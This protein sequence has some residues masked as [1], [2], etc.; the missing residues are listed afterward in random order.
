MCIFSGP[1][2]DVSKTK[3]FGRV[4]E[5]RQIIV[6]SMETEFDNPVA[7]IL[8]IPT[9]SRNENAVDFINMKEQPNF[10]KELDKPFE[11]RSR[12]MSKGLSMNPLQVHE[13]GNFIASFVPHRISFNRLD[14]AF[15]LSENVWDKLPQYND[16][17]FVVFQLKESGSYHP[18]AFSFPTKHKDKLYFPTVHVHEGTVEETGDFD[19]ALYFQGE[20]RQGPSRQQSYDRAKAYITSEVVDPEGFIYKT[21]LYGVLPNRDTYV[22]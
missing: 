19:H 14:E 3:I 18:M 6:Y 1:I 10:F 9:A 7:M 21:S 11:I 2:F 16:A 13:V 8:P 15:R 17:G 5:D 12:G 20:Y 22:Q 4:K